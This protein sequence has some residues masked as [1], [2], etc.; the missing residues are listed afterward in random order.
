MIGIT[1]GTNTSMFCDG[2]RMHCF[3]F[4]KQLDHMNMRPYF[5]CTNE[6]SKWFQSNHPDIQYIT[7]SSLTTP[8]ILQQFKTIIEWEVFLPAPLP[9][10]TQKHNIKVIRMNC[11]NLFHSTHRR[12]NEN[13]NIIYPN[14]LGE[15]Y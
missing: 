4:Y 2:M 3:I 5:L 7:Y 8:H 12:F 11:G 13:K 10:L 9:S 15:K 1:F 6:I 14:C